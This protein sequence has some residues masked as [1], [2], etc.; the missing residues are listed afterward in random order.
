MRMHAGESQR[1]KKK[2]INTTAPFVVLQDKLKKLCTDFRYSAGEIS[3]LQ[4][5]AAEIW[6]VSD[7]VSSLKE[8]IAAVSPRT[9]CTTAFDEVR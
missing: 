6:T 9:G 2:Q 4:F 1:L 5:A 3:A 8:Q 7:E